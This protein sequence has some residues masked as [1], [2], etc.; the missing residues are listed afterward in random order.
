MG[1]SKPRILKWSLAALL[2]VSYILICLPTSDRHSIKL[3]L[4]A[5]WK[6]IFF[7]WKYGLSY[8]C[9]CYWRLGTQSITARRNLDRHNAAWKQTTSAKTHSS[10]NQLRFY[11]AGRSVRMRS[12][13]LLVTENPITHW[14]HY[15]KSALIRII[16]RPHPVWL[17]QARSYV[18]ICLRS[19]PRVLTAWLLSVTEKGILTAPHSSKVAAAQTRR[20]TWQMGGQVLPTALSSSAGS[21]WATEGYKQGRTWRLVVSFKAV[22]GTIYSMAPNLDL[23]HCDFGAVLPV[24]H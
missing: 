4:D 2:I 6:Q 10:K 23:V 14:A 12:S 9:T 13:V 22:R 15:T 24:I 7:F 3:I 19:P 16:K 5:S 11:Q 21:L 17:K 18:T 1:S 20:K 8:S